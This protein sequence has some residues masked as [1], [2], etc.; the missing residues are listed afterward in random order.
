MQNFLKISRSG[1]NITVKWPATLSDYT[2][3]YADTLA[4]PDWIDV[5]SGI[6]IDGADKSFT[7]TSPNA[8]Y[9]RLTRP[10]GLFGEYFNNKD[11]IGIPTFT[12]FDAFVDFT[13]GATSPHPSIP[14]SQFSVR[15]SGRIQ[16]VQTGDYTFYTSVDDG[17]R[18][19][20]DGVKIIDD[21]VAPALIERTS[22]PLPLTAGQKYNLLLEYYEGNGDA[23]ASLKWAGPGIAKSVIPAV[24][25][26]PTGG[27]GLPLA[28]SNPLATPVSPTRI[29]LDWTDNSNNEDGFKILR[30]VSGG[31]FGP[32]IQVPAN[33][34]HYESN[35]LLPGTT[36]IHRLY[37]FNS[38][39]ESE[40]TSEARASTPQ[41]PA[42]NAPTNF[43]PT[44]TASGGV[45][46][47]WTD[48]ADNETSY[49][50]QRRV[51]GGSFGTPVVLTAGETT[52]A[53][54]GHTAGLLYIYQVWASN[55][56]GDSAFAE[57][58]VTAGPPTAP[59]TLTATVSSATNITLTWLDS[60][61]N[62]SGFEV[63]RKLFTDAGYTRVAQPGIN[64]L[65]ATN[66]ASS[67]STYIYRVRAINNA[68]ASPYGNE[69]TITA[70][71]PAVPASLLGSVPAAGEVDLAW[72][73]ASN[74]ENGFKIERRVSGGSVWTLV[75]NTAQ[76][77]TTYR[78]AAL[79]P[80]LTYIYNV[81]AFN[82]AGNSTTFAT[83][84]IKAGVPEI[85]TGLTVVATSSTNVTVTWTDNCTAETLFKLDRRNPDGTIVRLADLPAGTTTFADTNLSGRA[86]YG[87][88]IKAYN[89]AG[90]SPSSSEVA[91]VMPAPPANPNIP[92]LNTT[93]ATV[94]SKA[95]PGFMDIEIYQQNGRYYVRDKITA[96]QYTDPRPRRYY[97][98][99]MENVG[100]SLAQGYPLPERGGI[101][102]II[103]KRWGNGADQWQRPN[104]EAAVQWVIKP[105]PLGVAGETYI[106]TTFT[107]DTND[108][109]DQHTTR[110][111]AFQPIVGK[112]SPTYRYNV[113]QTWE[114]ILNH[115]ATHTAMGLGPGGHAKLLST[116]GNP[117][118]EMGEQGFIN[119]TQ[120]QIKTYAAGMAPGAFLYTDYEKQVGQNG[121][122]TYWSIDLP[123]V[124]ILQNYYVF[125]EELNRLVPTRMSGDYYRPLHWTNSFYKEGVATPLDPEFAAT[126]ADPNSGTEPAYR[127]FTHTDG[128]VRSLSSVV[129]AYN[130]DWYL[131]ENIYPDKRRAAIYQ[132]Y[133]G[134][135]DTINTKLIVPS[136]ASLI[137]FGWWGTDGDIPYKQYLRL[138]GGWL[139]Y[140]GRIQQSAWWIMTATYIGHLFGDGFHLWHDQA[141]ETNDR[142]QHAADYGTGPIVWEPDVAGT[143]SPAVLGVNGPHYP[144]E[145]RFNVIYSKLAEYR[146]KQYET[147]LT[148]PRS[149]VKYSLNVGIT[150]ISAIGNERNDLLQKTENKHP[151][152]FKWDNGDQVMVFLSWPFATQNEWTI[153]LEISPGVTR[154]V[155]MHKQWPMLRVFSKS[156]P[157]FGL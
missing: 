108:W 92:N 64:V 97:Y 79:D 13:W 153:R 143:P 65:T 104:Q 112:V 117:F 107:F 120:Q 88:L 103:C 147:F 40:L 86:T 102:Q 29:D 119:L 94:F 127:N 105:G 130:I 53:D 110:L 109:R 83:Y 78:D 54:S 156:N 31:E 128:Q 71:I 135:F 138:N 12:R 111:P 50:I 115:G 73:D 15:W 125:F 100:P 51:S 91:V 70:G 16:P 55:G 116:D 63:E 58:R 18:L 113:S 34:R 14:V 30:R 150:W 17:V 10:A 137:G 52:F 75:N 8:R 133:S 24:S 101:Y 23:R 25:F 44:V 42:P 7:D 122:S 76:N 149:V 26:H 126:V 32:P 38:V 5:T 36:Y 145:P 60:S 19:W 99:D 4:S 123:D 124:R 152:C 95:Y 134:L 74:N 20:L 61:N 77:A 81:T 2:L 43:I 11:L 155:T 82:G 49:K 28:P 67:G 154:D 118:N 57:V 22:A 33:T 142:T 139:S 3:E 114:D 140:Y 90:N 6:I 21:W 121:T 48:N 35:G 151:I 148:K 98:V 93:A 27:P 46:L 9:Y 144:R 80:N 84:R 39:R 1:S 68:G 129:K 89:L 141:P 131:K 56:G 136:S 47:S 85:P 72:G 37:A 66:S 132:I 41:V 87:Y 62:E 96:A 146:L 69:F 59:I 157:N 45:N 106:P